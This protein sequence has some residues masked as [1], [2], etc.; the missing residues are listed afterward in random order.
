[1][2]GLE[3]LTRTDSRPEALR[4]RAATFIRAVL[5]VAVL[6]AIAL[7]HAGP[8][9]AGAAV[10]VRVTDVRDVAAVVSWS[11]ATAE[12]GS[13]QWAA[14]VNNSCTNSAYG[15]TAQDTRGSGTTSTV[16]YVK[17]EPLSPATLYCY[18]PVS[19]GTTGTAS[20]FTTGP[21]VG[22]GAPDNLYGPLTIAGSLASDVILYATLSTNGVNSAVFTS[23]IKP[24]DQ[25]YFILNLSN[26]RTASNADVFGFSDASTLGLTIE[27]G[28]KGA[29]AQSI[30]VGTARTTVPFSITVSGSTPTPTHTAT[31]TPTPTQS[32]TATPT[33]T[34]TATVTATATATQTATAVPTAT[35]SVVTV[36]VLPEATAVAPGTAQNVV[37]QVQVPPGK[38]V[39]AITVDLAYSATALGISSCT[40]YSETI[41]N[42]A[43][44]G[45]TKVRLVYASTSGFSGTVSL[46]TIR[47]TATNADG[48]SSP[49][50]A[51]VDSAADTAGTTLPYAVVSSSVKVA[52]VNLRAESPFPSAAPNG[53][54]AVTV[55][56]VMATG[57][58]LGGW[59]I[60]LTYDNTK[61][62][63]ASCDAAASGSQCN[64]A[65]SASKVRLAG[66]STSGLAGTATVAV[67]TF[68]VTGVEGTSGTFTPDAV[69][70]D[71][72]TSEGDTLGSYTSPL[73]L[74][75]NAA[76]TV[77]S[78]SP[79]NGWPGGST[80]LQ[81]NGSNFFAGAT[82]SIGGLAATEVTVTASQ[83]T[84]KSPKK[85]AFGDTNNSG[86]VNATDS[87]CVLRSVAGLPST[88][89]CPAAGLT[90][91]V[92]VVVTNP[93]NT[94]STLSSGYTYKN[95]DMNNS[96]TVNATDSLCILRLVAGLPATTGC[97]RPVTSASVSSVGVRSSSGPRTPATVPAKVMLVETG[98][99]GD[100]VTV[101][102]RSSLPL[103]TALGSWLVDIAFPSGT[104]R[105]DRAIG[106]PDGVVNPLIAND[107]IRI[108]GATAV[109]QSGEA[110]LAS[111]TFI[112]IGTSSDLQ[113]TPILVGSDALGT[114][115]GAP[116]NAVALPFHIDVGP[117]LAVIDVGPGLA[118]APVVTTGQPVP[119]DARPRTAPV[120]PVTALQA[121]VAEP[122][123][124]RSV[125]TVTLTAAATGIDAT[126]ALV[127]AS[128]PTANLSTR[129]Y[130]DAVATLP[131][132]SII[133]L[134]EAI[135]G[136]G[137]EDAPRV[138]SLLIQMPSDELLKL[139]TFLTEIPA[140]QGSAILGAFAGEPRLLISNSAPCTDVFESATCNR[141]TTSSA[142]GGRVLV[143]ARAGTVV[144][145][146]VDDPQSWPEVIVPVFGDVVRLTV[147]Q[148]VT[149]LRVD[150]SPTALGE[151]ETGPLVGGIVSPIG[152]P[153]R[154]TAFGSSEFPVT[155]SI[156]GAP[157]RDG[158]IDTYLASVHQGDLF[159]GYEIVS[160]N[161]SAPGVGST[162]E[163]TVGEPSGRL[164]VA[165]TV[166]RA[167]VI[168]V[169]DDVA[170]MAGPDQS[171][172]VIGTAGSVSTVLEVVAPQ[173][174]AWIMVSNAATGETGWVH[175][176]T[177]VAAPLED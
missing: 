75:I 133:R 12:T 17:L 140:S 163:V 53:T 116:I 173:L 66:S 155:V 148:G 115:D 92:D 114:V 8:A 86:T 55:K 82:V 158:S 95:A 6:F 54:V 23:L 88:T 48:S 128:A 11:G 112:R 77:T 36:R 74:L 154:I 159:A 137:I 147:P 174:G 32:A 72:A 10:N 47:F 156:P 122:A 102:V 142:L 104:F 91:A 129:T 26:A 124:V 123:I 170:L 136:L 20:T 146:V 171:A 65:Y 25:G 43:Y 63:A 19:G 101:D 105:I 150:T 24:G 139:S 85:A 106:G 21:T 61:F 108:T 46:G 68:N 103:G 60:D 70:G 87:L 34:Q 151:T 83:I 62:T 130:I 41:C 15:T 120:V 145:V 162:V 84:A 96:G 113:V 44:G 118:V 125:E 73:S 57:S 51:T 164:I 14:A 42:T 81:I 166:G 161:G 22:L 175:A 40:T 143:P 56:A 177:V 167:S 117:G 78:V 9:E 16:H 71:L 109:G 39:G 111:L 99:S 121:P 169:A 13:V 31:P 126:S 18:R 30:L 37:I 134:S 149:A 76:P 153:M 168:T 152:V 93:N 69:A 2:N 49:L 138:V 59:L 141:Y 29:G 58:S 157:S 3:T 172:E 160:Q 80:A 107:R 176:T 165:A 131:G 90:S 50:T 7:A 33:P 144:E 1:M 64:I 5:A 27:G 94:S 135:A 45:L 89:G 119:S 79:D 110:I 127:S 97:P 132:A 35:V 52:R 67:V 28:A 100:S 4:Q 38:T 98:R